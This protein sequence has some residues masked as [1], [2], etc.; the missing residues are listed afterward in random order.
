MLLSVRELLVRQRTQLINALRGHAAEFGV[1][2]A[3]ARRACASCGR[4]SPRPM[5]RG[6]GG[7]KRVAL[8]GRRPS[9]SR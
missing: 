3:T 4:R 9:A 7:G 8:L 2:A 6:T 5:R 1:V